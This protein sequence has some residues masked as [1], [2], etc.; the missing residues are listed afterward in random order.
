[1]KTRFQSLLSNSTCTATTREGQL[2]ER[3]AGIIENQTKLQDPV[4]FKESLVENLS[5]ARGEDG[6][7]RL[8]GLWQSLLNNRLGGAVQVESVC[9]TWQ[10]CS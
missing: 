5:A 3:F 10:S 6:L 4:R 9:L 2:T 8:A 1:V 7:W